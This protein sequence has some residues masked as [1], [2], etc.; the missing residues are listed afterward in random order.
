M[1]GMI[2]RWDRGNS[3]WRIVPGLGQVKDNRECRAGS[4]E[5]RYLAK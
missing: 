5:V 2:G 1:L 4:R 3:E